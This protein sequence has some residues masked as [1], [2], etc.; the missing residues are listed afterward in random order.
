M[1]TLND[2]TLV[3]PSLHYQTDLSDL[4]SE[5]D[6]SDVAGEVWAHLGTQF[7]ACFS[8]H[9]TVHELV[10]LEETLP[11]AIGVA[12]AH[13]VELAGTL[14]GSGDQIPSGLV[15]LINIHTDTRSRSARGWMFMPSPKYADEVSANVWGSGFTAVV[16]NFTALLDDVLSIGSINPSNINPVVYSRTRRSRAESPYTFRVISASLNPTC[17]WL[18]RRMTSP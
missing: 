6:P 13:S 4:Q 16:N 2:G 7:R 8:N 5:P 10:A 18:K 14:T 11:P 3:E 15:P 9:C 12:G 17:H 1:C